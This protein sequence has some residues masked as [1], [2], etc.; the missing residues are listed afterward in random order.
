MSANELINKLM[1]TF[2]DEVIPDAEVQ[3]KSDVANQVAAM[4]VNEDSEPTL[5]SY[6]TLLKN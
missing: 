3:V 4:L 5:S 2:L 6:L 1:V